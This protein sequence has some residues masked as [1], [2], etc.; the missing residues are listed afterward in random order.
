MS[1]LQLLPDEGI[2][3]LSQ[4]I[5]DLFTKSKFTNAQTTETIKIMVLQHAVKYHKARDWIKQQD[6]SQLT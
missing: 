2:H 4:H 3:A 6:Q 1:D 5:C